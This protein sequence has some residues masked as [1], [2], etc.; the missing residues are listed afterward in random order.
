[1]P[2]RR[3]V[4]PREVPV[5]R[6][7]DGLAAAFLAALAACSATDNPDRSA[8]EPLERAPE[9]VAAS[10]GSA[11][12]AGAPP[13]PVKPES[14][15]TQSAEPARPA[16]AAGAASLAT[17]S[18]GSVGDRQVLV[19][20]YLRK[21]WIENR[22]IAAKVFEQLL[23]AHVTRL[24]ADRLG[25]VLRD[26]AVEAE[27]ADTVKRMEERLSEG[28]KTTT[29]DQYAERTLRI[30]PKL[31]RANL[32]DEK[33]VQMLAERCV[34]TWLLENDQRKVRITEIRDPQALE[35]A[36]AE[37]AAGKTFEEVAVAHGMGD[38][39]A[40]HVTPVNVARAESS[41]LNK[42][43]FATPLGTVGG[44][45]EQSGRWLLFVV[46]EELPGRE[47]GWAALREDVE[48][49]IAGEPVSDH[50]FVQWRAAMERRYAVDDRPF[51]EAVEGK[52]P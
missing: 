21:L 33:I 52:R 31:F 15:P 18:L 10:V 9:A 23:F 2:R 32:R 8:L 39:E 6:A 37:L 5:T 3:R 51:A 48:R 45:L 47:G 34:R 40:A 22:S 19:A 11:Q 30:D 17:A 38:D 44:P 46:D 20:D 25:I 29:L 12:G 43:V 42:L 1:V 41:T 24:E 4:P 28:G 36:R 16:P 27:L 14:G 13:S 35:T 50:E 49:G 7:S 26:E